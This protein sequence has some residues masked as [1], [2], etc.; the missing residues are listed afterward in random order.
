MQSLK[1]Q[2]LPFLVLIRRF[3]EFLTYSL[4][5]KYPIVYVGIFSLL[6]IVDLQAVSLMPYLL[7]QREAI[8]LLVL[9]SIKQCAPPL[10]SGPLSLWPDTQ[11]RMKKP[12]QQLYLHLPLLPR[13]QSQPLIYM[14][15]TVKPDIDET[16][17]TTGI[18]KINTCQP[19]NFGLL[20]QTPSICKRKLCS[21]PRR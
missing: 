11:A 6:P 16:S 12:W 18:Q 8:S 3:G 19:K 21:Q 17:V 15:G 1:H 14:T 10:F 9:L 13:H 5:Y 7:I 20:N 2:H 4:I